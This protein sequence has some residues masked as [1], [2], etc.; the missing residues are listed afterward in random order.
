MVDK[1]HMSYLLKKEKL[2]QLKAGLHAIK[3]TATA[4]GR[5]YGKYLK[6][7]A[8]YYGN[9][10]KNSKIGQG[11]SK[12]WNESKGFTSQQASQLSE[13]ANNAWSSVRTSATNFLQKGGDIG[14]YIQDKL[15]S[16][17]VNSWFEN[18]KLGIA[19]GVNEFLKNIGMRKET[20]NFMSKMSTT[21]LSDLSKASSP[22]VRANSSLQQTTRQTIMNKANQDVNDI[23]S[24]KL[25]KKSR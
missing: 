18:A 3:T 16:D 2:M 23:L 10:I 7:E 24:P 4:A 12:F 22:N 21:R 8:S 14:K 6:N 25:N 15:N 13:F 1:K 5:S 20:D 9:K 19:S 11:V 17:S